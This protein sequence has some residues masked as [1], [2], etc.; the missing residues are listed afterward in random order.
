MG[1]TVEEKAPDRAELADGRFTSVVPD[2]HFGTNPAKVRFTPDLTGYPE[3][4]ASAYRKRE[5]TGRPS[6]PQKGP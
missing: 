4:L 6:E 5:N 2:L 3:A 1:L